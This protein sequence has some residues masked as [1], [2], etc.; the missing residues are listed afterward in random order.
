[1]RP[2][3]TS[4]VGTDLPL[5]GSRT[6]REDEPATPASRAAMHAIR[7]VADPRT[8]LLDRMSTFVLTVDAAGNIAYANAAA[9]R[10]LGA[11]AESPVGL[12]VSLIAPDL[13]GSSWSAFL[14]TLR[15]G[16]VITA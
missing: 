11:E 7:T 15:A 5:V 8:A 6:I 12:P 10:A 14:A 9:A 16:G 3:G 4:S 2:R 1:M 13:A